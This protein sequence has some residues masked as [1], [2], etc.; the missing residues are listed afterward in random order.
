MTNQF[1]IMKR[2]ETPEEL[3]AVHKILRVDPQRYLRIHNGW[4]HE[5]PVD[6]YA[7]FDRHYVW[8]KLGEPQ[9]ALDDLTKAAE[10]NPKPDPMFLMARAHVYRHLGEYEKALADLNQ[11]DALDPKAW[12][13]DIV[14]GLL[15]QADTY[16]RLGDEAHALATC[17]RLPEDFWTPGVEGAPGGNKAEVAEKLRAVAAAARGRNA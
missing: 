1:E 15:F 16:A 17:A 6:N 12:E 9:R 14:F 10:L 11:A 13:T 7:Y 5:N 3:L 8:L 4:I 2:P